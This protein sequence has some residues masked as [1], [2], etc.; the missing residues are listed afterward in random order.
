MMLFACT[1][2][3]PEQT[4]KD[5]PSTPVTPPAPE[6]PKDVLS[7][8][9]SFPVVES[10]DF[11][12]K[13]G[14]KISAGTSNLSEELARVPANSTSAVFTFP[15]KINDGDLLRYP[16]AA[17]SNV[18]VLPANWNYTAGKFDP[19]IYPFAGKVAL[20]DVASEE[21]PKV[22][23][24]NAMAML[25]FSFTGNADITSATL[26]AVGGQTLY[27][28][29]LLSPEAVVAGNG[30]AGALTLNFDQPITLTSSAAA[31]LYVP[32]RPNNYTGGF[33]LV[34]SDAAGMSATVKF[35]ADGK[36]IAKE[37]V[38]NIPVEYKPGRDYTLGPL[39][40]EEMN[41]DGLRQENAMRIGQFNIWSNE[42]R[43]DKLAEE[44]GKYI[45]RSWE[46]AGD[47][48][49]STAVSLDCDIICFNEISESLSK[50]NGLQALM[51][52]YSSEYT[53]SLNW[54][55]K[56]GGFWFWSYEEST[57]ANGFAYKASSVRLEDSGK[58]WLNASGSLDSDSDAGGN[59][60]CVWAK[61]TQLSTNKV[62][63]VAVTHLSI[64]SQGTSTESG[65]YEKGFWNLQT[66]KNLTAHL[67]ARLGATENDTILL[68][69]D[70]NSN[71][72]TDNQGFNYLN[73]EMKEGDKPVNASM[74]FTDSRDYLLS[75]GNLAA[76]EIPFEGTSNGTYNSVTRLTKEEYR[77][78]HIMFRNCSVSNYRSYRTTYSV[79]EDA[80]MTQWFPSDHLPISV[81]VVL[82]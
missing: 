43:E 82:P 29:F 34:L 64:E 68:V 72:D 71:S 26:E 37:D 24:S 48:V 31:E 74:I 7:L 59:R 54:P 49:A 69:G 25:K 30:T 52:K 79:A 60:T 21:T 50:A 33:K 4:G 73:G 12:W 5:E 41:Y 75:N 81:D 14:D 45:Y 32:V 35:Y 80:S 27:G 70:L 47:A 20:S 1:K 67:A 15:Q 13:N 55:N 39:V 77:L 66:A 23:L 76:T 61:F 22:T 53:Y 42:D 28:V 3:G 40:G 38:L 63:Y 62:F 65:G 10:Q 44:T 58:F 8:E 16:V 6:E 78:D 2:E 11:Y 46:Y 56:T 18:F 19:A 17:N 36:T 9:V 57:Y 51:E